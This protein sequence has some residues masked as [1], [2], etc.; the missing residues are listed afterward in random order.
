MI[1]G[2]LTVSTAVVTVTVLEIVLAL[3]R[4]IAFPP[5]VPIVLALFTLKVM[6]LI[7][8]GESMVTS[9]VPAALLKVAVSGLVVPAL[10]SWP[11]GVLGVKGFVQFVPKLQLPVV[12]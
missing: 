1:K 4:V 7:F 8:H 12:F 3:V 2:A 10:V 9:V 5:V 6:F 11:G